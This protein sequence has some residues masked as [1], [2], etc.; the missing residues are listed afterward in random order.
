M[1]IV[2]DAE[3]RKNEILDVAER[4][5]VTKGFDHTST[6]DILHEI[7]IA[8]GTLYYHFKS[9][10]DILDAMI[11]RIVEQIIKKAQVIVRDQSVPVL[12]RMRDTVIALN[13][14]NDTSH[15]ILEQVHRPQNALMH[16][17]MQERM[18]SRVNP[19]IVEILKDGIAQGI[20]HT[21][22]PEEAVEMIMLY[23]NVAFDDLADHSP[24]ELEKKIAGFIYNTERILGMNEGGL[25]EALL[26]IFVQ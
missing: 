15:M 10:E 7:G 3:E 8:R 19:L 23:A 17:K 13:V 20:F 18:L 2:K 24:E 5:F 1:R 16:Q 22:Y 11:E 6:N 4:L 9:K 26:P 12:D 25:A 14:D 21:E